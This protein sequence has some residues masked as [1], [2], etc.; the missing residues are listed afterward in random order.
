MVTLISLSFFLLKSITLHCIPLDIWITSGTDFTLSPLKSFLLKI[1]LFLV[2][3]SHWLLPQHPSLYSLLHFTGLS[4]LGF[5]QLPLH[6]SHFLLQSHK[7][8]RFL[9][10]PLMPASPFPHSSTFWTKFHTGQRLPVFAFWL[11]P[12]IS[13]IILSN[14]LLFISTFT[15]QFNNFAAQTYPGP[16]VLHI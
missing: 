1:H 16:S 3:L 2:Y 5:L 14:P 6:S 10:S 13:D 7:L 4:I 11:F 12:G 15:F 9:T 8:F